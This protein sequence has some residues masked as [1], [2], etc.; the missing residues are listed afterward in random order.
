[1]QAKADRV[2]KE[3]ALNSLSNGGVAAQMNSQQAEVLNRSCRNAST[4]Q[5]ATWPTS[6]ASTARMI[7]NT[8]KLRTK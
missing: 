4:W 1:M 7:K 8:G 5:R 6:R 2:K 3:A